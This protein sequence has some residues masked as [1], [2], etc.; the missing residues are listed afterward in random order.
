M[1][2][3]AEGGVTMSKSSNNPAPKSPMGDRPWFTWTITDN[4][5][6]V[7]DEGLTRA[8][9]ELSL[10][11]SLFTHKVRALLKTDPLNHYDINVLPLD[12]AT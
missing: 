9:Q 3:P 6:A 11:G 4:L 8:P 10:I 1:P 12:A 5:G 7:V 2:G